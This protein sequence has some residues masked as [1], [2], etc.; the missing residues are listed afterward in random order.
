MAVLRI[1]ANLAT[2]EP[3]ALAGF[4]RDLLA[5]G[6]EVGLDQGWIVALA[7]EAAAA[8]QISFA[9]DGGSGQPVPGISIEVDDWHA[10]LARG[11]AAGL[12]PAYGPIQ[13]PW[14][15]RRFFFRDPAA[16][17]W[18]P[19]WPM[20]RPGS[21]SEQQPLLQQPMHAF[22]AID[23]LRHMEIHRQRAELIGVGGTE[24]RA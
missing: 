12:P 21:E 17:A 16:A 22:F 5:L 8:P 13:E 7:S 6:L 20:R 9:S 11:H 1:V 3:M 15:V 24:V 10:V 4:Y 18:L 2:P 14:G 19:F 23:R